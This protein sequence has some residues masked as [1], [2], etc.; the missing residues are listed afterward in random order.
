MSSS[1]FALI[2][3]HEK[4]ALPRVNE[5]SFVAVEHEL[6]VLETRTRLPLDSGPV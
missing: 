4:A 1:D 2:V 6:H 5:C 3:K